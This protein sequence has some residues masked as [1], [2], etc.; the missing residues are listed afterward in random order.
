MSSHFRLLQIS[1]NWQFASVVG[2]ISLAEYENITTS[3]AAEEEEEQR[4][5]D[6]WIKMEAA[7]AGLERQMEAATEAV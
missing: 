7:A 6:L 2:D 4:R 5:T 3:A 1:E